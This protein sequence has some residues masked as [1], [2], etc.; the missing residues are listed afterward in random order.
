LARHLH[1]LE[2]FLNGIHHREVDM[3][4]PLF[5][6]AIVTSVVA[7]VMACAMPLSAAAQDRDREREGRDGNDSRYYSQRDANCAPRR[8]DSYR[9]RDQRDWDRRDRDA[10]PR[11]DGNWQR[12]YSQPTYSPGYDQ[13]RYQ[14]HR[15]LGKSVLIVG[16]SAAAGA[17]IGGLA[18]GGKGAGIG[19]IAGGLGGLIFDRATAHH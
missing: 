1:S 11:R 8:D 15:S 10:D 3:K 5:R 17:A 7:A 19:A 4:S 9:D 18:G 12:S 6:N 13:P 16:G 2:W 14:H